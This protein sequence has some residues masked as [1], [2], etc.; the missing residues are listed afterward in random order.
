M[1]VDLGTQGHHVDVARPPWSVLPQSR[2]PPPR[3]HSILTLKAEGTHTL[4][5][6]TEGLDPDPSFIF[7]A[8]V[9][10]QFRLGA[11]IFHISTEI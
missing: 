2:L 9:W 6:I 3:C 8:A 7:S 11:W 5:Y 10:Q 1:H 4:G